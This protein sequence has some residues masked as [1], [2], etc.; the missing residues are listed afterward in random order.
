MIKKT[1]LFIAVAVALQHGLQAASLVVSPGQSIQA[2]INNATAGDNITIQSGSYNGSL[3]ID[4]GLDIRGSNGPVLIQGN[5]TISN[6][7]LPVYL[8]DLSFTTGRANISNSPNVRLDGVTLS[9]GTT[10]SNGTFYA[11]KSSLGNA[12]FSN[13][14][15][16]LQRT[17]S[18]TTTTT[19]CTANH[20]GGTV[21]GNLTHTHGNLTIF[22]TTMSASNITLLADQKSWICY[23]GINPANLTISGG[24]SEVVGNTFQNTS[25]NGATFVTV[26]GNSTNSTFRNNQISND[27][28]TSNGTATGMGTGISV[29]AASGL[30]R[31]F[32]NTFY[33]IGRAIQV[34][35]NSGVEIRGNIHREDSMFAAS[36][37][38]S[39][40]ATG[41]ASAGTII[42]HNNFQFQMIGGNQTNNI[43][44]NPLLNT[45][46]M[47][48]G[49]S[50]PSR[51]AG[52][53]D[54]I[55][56]DID[57]SRNDQ[58][59]FGGHSYDPE[60][61]TTLKPVVLSGEV[62]PLYIKRGGAVTVRARAAVVAP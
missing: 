51:D 19:N 13:S 53:P 27:G 24:S 33:D 31:I 21:S 28:I 5:L 12:T 41:S 18:I 23:S 55:F 50:S 9:I 49:A 62:S 34:T 20:I 25:L 44:L 58:G 1:I 16:T 4:K 32:N 8:K 60:G 17:S 26:A 37:S 36:S 35:G 56:N 46:N 48:L 15:V 43:N 22:R 57:G 39:V 10:F 30:T 7:A 38:F 61:W 59:C 45:A 40:N 3:T 47:T 2:A 11:L 29:T 42:S 52:P 54:A 14:T 6:S